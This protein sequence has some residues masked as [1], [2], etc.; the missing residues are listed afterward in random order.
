MM[1]DY[2]NETPKYDDNMFAGRFSMPSTVFDRIY[3]DV[4]ARPEF[5]RKFDVVLKTGLYPM[6]RKVAA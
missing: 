6:Q 5:V 2:F 1:T 4:S 3:K